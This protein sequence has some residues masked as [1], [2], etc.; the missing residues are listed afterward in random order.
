MGGN[1]AGMAV[2]SPN[3]VR[4][5]DTT[6]LFDY[7]ID[8]EGVNNLIEEYLVA[9]A[10][11]PVNAGGALAVQ[12]IE[13]EAGGSLAEN[14]SAYAELTNVLRAPDM[15]GLDGAVVV[16]GSDDG[17]V[18]TDQSPQMWAALNA[19]G[20][21]SHLYTVVLRDGGESGTTATAIVAGPLFDGA[22]LGDYESPFAGHGW[23]GSDT[24]LVVKTGF[25]QLWALM[26]GGTVSAG[27]T[28]VPG[29]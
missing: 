26:A 9:S 1:A 5:D 11:A 15:A 18:P 7:L 20:V 19:V 10:V 14:P 22:G 27:A 28:P 2:A 8:V 4:L 25:E 23:E 21:P 24:Q 16:H 17:L 29:L 6:P 13:K 12:E 3:A